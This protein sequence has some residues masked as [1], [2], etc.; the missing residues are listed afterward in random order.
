MKYKI[1]I[2]NLATKDITD[3]LDYIERILLNPQAADD[4]HSKIKQDI[5]SLSTMPKRHPVIND[6][7]LSGWGI[8]YIVIDSFIAF[9]NVDDDKKTVNVIR[10]VYGKRNWCELLNDLLDS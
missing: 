1:F 4:L 3:I 8:R 10:V 7:L 5:N 2:S 9:Y 6:P